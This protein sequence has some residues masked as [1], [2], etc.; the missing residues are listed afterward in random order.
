[1]ARGKC[2]FRQRDVTVAIRA[3]IAAGISCPRVEIDAAGRI[4]IMPVADAVAAAVPDERNPW[5]KVLHAADKER[6][7]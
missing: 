3:A 5:D 2:N 4:A 7:A 6:T 1:M